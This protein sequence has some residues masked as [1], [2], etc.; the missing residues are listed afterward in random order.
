MKPGD[1]VEA[2]TE[3]VAGASESGLVLIVPFLS[4][5]FM[6][7][8]ENGL[9]CCF[10]PNVGIWAP[11]TMVEV[12]ATAMAAVGAGSDPEEKRRMGWLHFS[13]RQASW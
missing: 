11:G 5:F 3:A 9:V 12:A 2:S 8:G 1:R 4:I 10:F 7:T 13:G 6:F